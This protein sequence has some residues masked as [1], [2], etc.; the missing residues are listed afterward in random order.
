MKQKASKGTSLPARLRMGGFLMSY[1][2]GISLNTL[3]GTGREVDLPITVTLAEPEIPLEQGSATW[4]DG[5]FPKGLPK[6]VNY[7]N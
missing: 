5:I 4:A 7:S 6:K 2:L 1:R 3:L